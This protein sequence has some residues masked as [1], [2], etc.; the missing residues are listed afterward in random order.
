MF[1]GQLK[2]S[3][4]WKKIFESI[5]AI[6]TETAIT[7]KDEGIT[8]MAMDTVHVTMISLTL[9]KSD[10][11]VFELPQDDLYVLGINTTDLLKMLKRADNSDII[12][13]ECDP[14]ERKIVLKM[15]RLD[16][17]KTKKF[18]LSTIDLEATRLPLQQLMEIPMTSVID[19][20]TK[21]IHEALNDAEI[22]TDAIR[23]ITSEDSVTFKSE[24]SIGEME[25]ILEKEEFTSEKMGESEGTFTISKLKSIFKISSLVESVNLGIA[26]D[27]PARL[28]FNIMEQSKII[29]FLAPRVDQTT[30][31]Y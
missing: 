3:T 22:Y 12:T 8:L 9:M 11:E 13:F 25:Y 6:V 10:F 20:N 27:A 7:I 17:K 14:L 18:S 2:D 19:I 23:I 1:K 31:E 21:F 24:G 29:Y 26:S 4:V 28:L 15:S 16:S 30:E 5:N